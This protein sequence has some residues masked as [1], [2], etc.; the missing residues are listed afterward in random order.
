MLRHTTLTSALFLRWYHWVGLEGEVELVLEVGV[1]HPQIQD[2]LQRLER[3]G[4][5]VQTH[6]PVRP[7]QLY[8]KPFSYS[9]EW[10]IGP[11]LGT[12]E[13][14]PDPGSSGAKL[15]GSR[16]STHTPEEWILEEPTHRKPASL[17]QASR[18]DR[19]LRWEAWLPPAHALRKWLATPPP[20][21]PPEWYPFRRSSSSRTSGTGSRSAECT[22]G[23]EV[24]LRKNSCK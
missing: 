24:S 20:L 12:S 3:K 11:P 1:V 8:S 16:D 2:L 22:S 19:V 6:R 7:S 21:P 14:T 9:H 17:P 10:W 23:W 18:A 4:N 5:T 13:E 15:F